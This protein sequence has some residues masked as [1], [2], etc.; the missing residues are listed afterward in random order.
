MPAD[1]VA[2]VAKKMQNEERVRVMHN[3]SYEA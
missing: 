1:V 3:D 2:A